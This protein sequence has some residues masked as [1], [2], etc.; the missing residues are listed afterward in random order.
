MDNQTFRTK[1]EENLTPERLTIINRVR[2]T[3]GWPA[4]D[5]EAMIDAIL[6][7]HEELSSEPTT[8]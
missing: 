8:P 5:K 1:L 3:A 4:L 6:E 7:I 2:Q